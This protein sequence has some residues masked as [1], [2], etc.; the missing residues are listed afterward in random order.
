MT[1]YR[2]SSDHLRMVRRREEEIV[3]ER[4]TKHKEEEE[5]ITSSTEGRMKQ[6]TLQIHSG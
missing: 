5:G 3:S 1:Y 4:L 6:N 2:F